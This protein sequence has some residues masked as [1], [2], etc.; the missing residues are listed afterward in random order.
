ML[1]GLCAC[2]SMC[3]GLILPECC[4]ISSVLKLR[5]REQKEQNYLHKKSQASWD[6]AFKGFDETCDP[7]AADGQMSEKKQLIESTRA[8]GQTL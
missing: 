7:R 2:R 4:I 1:S 3:E 5:G 8:K 6:A